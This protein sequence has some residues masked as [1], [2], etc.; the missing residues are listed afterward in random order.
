MSYIG[1]RAVHG[2]FAEPAQQTA[3]GNVEYVVE[4]DGFRK[5]SGSEQE[6]FV[7]H[8]WHKAIAEPMHV[9]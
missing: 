9:N 1:K 7:A 3:V 6:G 5:V 8:H 4:S 2:L